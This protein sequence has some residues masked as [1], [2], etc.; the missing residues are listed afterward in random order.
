VPV[1]GAPLST[2]DRSLL[3]FFQVAIDPDGRANI[4]IADNAT[5]PGQNISAY[6]IQ[7]TGY[8]LATGRKLAPL[9][10]VQP[11]TNCKPDASFTDPSGDATE[12]LVAT[13]LP[14]QPALDITRGYLSWD[15]RAKKVSFHV[16]VLDATQD[17]PTG[18]TG[19]SSTTRSA[20]TGRAICS[21]VRTTSPVTRPIS[22]RR[23]RTPSPLP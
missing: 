3:D 20:S 5:S 6:T 19:R 8:S 4:A 23:S 2:G 14:S 18:A 13:P 15:A 10:V 12:V 21:A 11:R 9:H 22:N 7:L 1:S 16:V 17:P